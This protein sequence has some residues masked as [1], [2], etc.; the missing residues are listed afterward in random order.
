MTAKEACK[1]IQGIANNIFLDYTD[2]RKSADDIKDDILE[3][4]RMLHLV[5]DNLEG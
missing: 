2:N 4:I 1:E 5:L 3:V